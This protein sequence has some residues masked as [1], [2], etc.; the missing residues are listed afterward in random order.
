MSTALFAPLLV[1]FI[2]L[3]SWITA[4][5]LAGKRW[6][7]ELFSIDFAL[8][9]VLLSS[10]AA[11]TLG[12]IA[13]DLPFNDRILLSSKTAQALV[14][15]AGF[16]FGLANLLLLGAV[17]LLGIAGA[18][19]ISIGLGLI[20]HTLLNFRSYSSGTALAGLALLAAGVL[21]NASACRSRDLAAT[22]PV[23]KVTQ[24]SAGTKGARSMKGLIVALI[25][26]IFLGVI[27]TL[28]EGGI[29]GDLGL[30]PYAGL[31]FFSVAT[32]LST[33]V[34]SIV[35]FNIAL[36]G[37]R[38][39]VRSYFKGQPRQHLFGIA[40]GA[41]WAAGILA[42]FHAKTVAAETPRQQALVG[43]LPPASALLSVLWGTLICKEF[44][45]APKKAQLFLAG[46]ATM[47][48][49]GFLLLGLAYVG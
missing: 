20:V 39:T 16:V 19:P 18:F 31:L 28:A 7:F 8:G 46:T 5:K 38:L 29:Y 12:N 13:S 2:C 3:G 24:Q 30:G 14:F 26:G 35:F 11:F 1:S 37:S 45:V 33:L 10:V 49:G 44:S 17:S 23:K 43:I 22:P 41:L 36:E 42:A 25:A 34:F 27:Y 6:R 40:G 48:V 15:S 32:L 9:T 47:L 21:L 4:F